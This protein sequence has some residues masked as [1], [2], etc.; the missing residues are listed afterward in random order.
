LPAFLMA[1]FGEQRSRARRWGSDDRASHHGRSRTGC[2][3][4]WPEDE[5][6]VHRRAFD[7]HIERRNRLTRHLP[8]NRPVCPHA[9]FGENLRIDLAEI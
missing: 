4:R 8:L 6:S 1:L 9:L 3:F 7:S 5:E 2:P